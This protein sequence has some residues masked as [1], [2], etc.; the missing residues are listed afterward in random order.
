[1]YLGR[2][3]T[4]LNVPVAVAGR[5]VLAAWVFGI[6]ILLQFIQTEITASQSV[7]EYSSALRRIEDLTAQLDAGNI[8]PCMHFGVARFLESDGNV[9][10][11]KSLRQALKKCGDECLGQIAMQDCTDKARKGT[12]VLVNWVLPLVNEGD[13]ST[14]LVSGDD[15]LFTYLPWYPMHGRWP[16]SV[17]WAAVLLLA[18]FGRFALFLSSNIVYDA[19]SSR[20]E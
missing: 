16:A 8:L 18:C 14:G 15:Y 7:P 12:H 1:M 5:V 4:P 11:L 10:H 3:P 19:Q 9:P 20:S 13:S 2:S 6:F 17:L